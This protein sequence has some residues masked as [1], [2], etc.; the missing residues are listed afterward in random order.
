VFDGINRTLT[1]DQHFADAEA[2]VK[3]CGDVETRLDAAKDQALSQ[4]ASIY[5]LLTTLDDVKEEARKVRLEL[6]KLVEQRKTAIRT[7]IVSNAQA[8]YKDHITALNT[9]IGRVILPGPLTA[10]DFAG[11]IKGRRTVESL[12]NAADTTL[13]TAKA[14]ANTLADRVVLNLEHLAQQ[15]PE[16]SGLFPDANALAL[17]QPDDLAAMITA[18]ISTHEANEAAA[19]KAKEVQEQAEIDAAEAKPTSTLAADPRDALAQV[20]A[21]GPALVQQPASLDEMHAIGS[22]ISNW[23][24]PENAGAMLKLG[25]INARLSPIALTADGLKSL[26]FAHVATDKAAKLYKESD[27]QKI[28]DALIKTV[29][30]AKHPDMLLKAA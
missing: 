26:G 13:A 6:T 2:A 16:Y 11:A 19:S 18:R 10:P 8:A 22:G 12:K 9:R 21:T 29:T 3:W 30:M 1:T 25:E 20:M 27:F 23:T 24:E 7:E 28:C 5:D 4:T 15:K 17:K 14:A